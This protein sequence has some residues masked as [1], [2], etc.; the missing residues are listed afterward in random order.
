[1]MNAGPEKRRI[2]EKVVSENKI[3]K[4]LDIGTYC[5]YSAIALSLGLV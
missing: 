2:L 1:M 4:V 3:K 5:G